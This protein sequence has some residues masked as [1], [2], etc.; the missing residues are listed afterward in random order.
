[1]KNIG[2]TSKLKVGLSKVGLY[3]PRKVYHQMRYCLCQPGREEE[4]KKILK[5]YPDAVRWEKEGDMQP[6]DYA[7]WQR[8]LGSAEALIKCDPTIMKD[9]Q[10]NGGSVLQAA[11]SK[12]NVG[13]FN[14][15]KGL[16]ADALQIDAEGNNLLHVVAQSRF[17]PEMIPLL[18]AEGVDPKARNAKGESPLFITARTGGGTLLDEFYKL[19]PDINQRDG[20][21][22]TMLMAAAGGR[23]G[24]SATIK[25]LAQLGA[26]LDAKRGDGASALDIALRHYNP[27][28]AMQLIESGAE[29]DL[30]HPSLKSCMD[31]F[32]ECGDIGFDMLIDEKKQEVAEKEARRLAAEAAAQAAAKEQARLDDITR[33]MDACTDGTRQT[34]TVKKPLQLKAK[35]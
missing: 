1:M 5:K 30:N 17:H 3:P 33:T 14:F 10:Q 22:E 35:P 12:G 8:Q 7:I 2:T 18:L 13:L 31:F 16:G 28:S 27:D 6:I 19:D 15:L 9:K 32:R 26:D 23:D 34:V 29:L 25:R 20:K 4:L 21:G 11:V 24:D